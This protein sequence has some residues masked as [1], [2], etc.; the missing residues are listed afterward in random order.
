MGLGARESDAFEVVSPKWTPPAATSYQGHERPASI[1]ERAF[2][3]REN[4]TEAGIALNAPAVVL[5]FYFL[6]ARGAL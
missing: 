3:L 2:A 6:F 1:L 4:D 5:F